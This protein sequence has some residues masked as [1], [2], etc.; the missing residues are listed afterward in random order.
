MRVVM[1]GSGGS[2]GVPLVGGPDGRGN[3]GACDPGEPRNRRTRAAIVIES[4]DGQRLL[5]DTPPDL[6]AQLLANA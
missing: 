4:A 3:W 5:V 2:A 6:R 1:L